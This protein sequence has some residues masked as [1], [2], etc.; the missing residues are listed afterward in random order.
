MPALL[1]GLLLVLVSYIDTH[2]TSAQPSMEPL[3]SLQ[4]RLC[5]NRMHNTSR[6]EIEITKSLLLLFPRPKPGRPDM[7]E[8]ASASGVLAKL[9]Y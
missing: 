8:P 5:E 9:F 4:E 1:P 3:P 7:A 6:T 2:H